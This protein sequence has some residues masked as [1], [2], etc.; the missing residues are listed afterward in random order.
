MRSLWS[1][2]KAPRRVG[3]TSATCL[4]VQ[5]ASRSWV[6]GPTALGGACKVVRSRVGKKYNRLSTR[7]NESESEQSSIDNV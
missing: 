3:R 2:C 5:W 4:I 7:Q 1:Q 6:V